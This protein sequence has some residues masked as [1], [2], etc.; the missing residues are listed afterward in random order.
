MFT[1]G[2]VRPH[3]ES[4]AWIRETYAVALAAWQR[5]DLGGQF[6]L[7]LSAALALRLQHRKI[8]V[9]GLFGGFHISFASVFV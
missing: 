7:T 3:D 1:A 4:P 5:G 6:A 2:L 8:D 9:V